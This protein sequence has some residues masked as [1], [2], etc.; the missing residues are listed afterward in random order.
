VS[1]QHLN[2]LAV[3]ARSLEGFR[4]GDRTGHTL[5]IPGGAIGARLGD[6]RVVLAGLAL[7]IAGGRIPAAWSPFGT[8][9]PL[10]HSTT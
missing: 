6:K 8:Q 1:E 10:P 7:M 3:A 5:A 4:L 2:A 9:P